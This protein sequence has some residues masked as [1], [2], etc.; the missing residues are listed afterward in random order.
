M[1]NIN[2]R[3]WLGIHGSHA[4]TLGTDGPTTGSAVLSSIQGLGTAVWDYLAYR[5]N[6][7]FLLRYWANI[8]A[9]WHEQP[10]QVE[11]SE[12]TIDLFEDA[13]LRHRTKFEEN[14][15]ISLN[16]V[17][18][19]GRR[20]VLMTQPLARQSNAQDKFNDSIRSVASRE[21]V[22]LIDLEGELDQDRS[23]AFLSDNIH[24]NTPGSTAVGNTIASAIAPL[25]GV[26]IETPV[27][28]R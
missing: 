11:I 19:I 25:F 10:L 21:Q 12:K 26:S 3:L 22:L 18:A 8:A 4:A 28:D 27:R 9:A 17:R 5:S 24:L 23:W 15:H 6:S 20:P 16:L 14:L 13:V 2:D 1:H 7:L